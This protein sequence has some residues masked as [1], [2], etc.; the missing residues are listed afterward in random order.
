L[1]LST[2]GKT[3]IGKFSVWGRF[4]YHR[5]MED[6]TRLRH[7]TRINADAPVYF[8]SLKNNYYERD[9]YTL[10]TALQ[11]GF[12][13]Q[14]L[15]LTLGLDYRVGNHF[16]NNDPRGRISDFQ[17]DASAAL[18]RRFESGDMHLEVVYGYGRERV[19]VGYKNDQ[20]ANNTADPRYINYF[21]NGFGRAQEQVRDIRYNNDFDR[22]GANVLLSKQINNGNILFVKAGW[23]HEQQ[24]FKFYDSS[25]LMYNPLNKYNKN[26]YSFD[27]LWKQ[28]NLSNTPRV[29][30]LQGALVDGRDY[31]YA[32]EQNNYVFRRNFVQLEVSDR[33]RNT[34]VKGGLLFVSSDMEDGFAGIELAYQ[35]LSPSIKLNQYIPLL[36]QSALVPTV[37]VGY[38]K[39]LHHNFVLP[40]SFVSTFTQTIMQ[41]NYLYYTTSS[42][43]LGV[44][45]D[46]ELTRN[47]NSSFVLGIQSD[48]FRHS[49]MEET[50]SFIAS[51]GKDRLQT[52]VRLTAF[53]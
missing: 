41:H 31:N 43:Q 50:S 5:S 46:Y 9:V 19:G 23:L 18:G 38:N 1:D 33:Y 12:A 10:Q 34:A 8:G 4:G 49:D 47:A 45:V 37:S 11:Y 6:S 28:G 14:R 15:P 16:S 39:V 29:Y 3:A 17:L 27:I 35:T 40:T 7:Q 52:N 32:I 21:M 2:E 44:G 20:Y 24:F 26:S 42:Y 36:K 48:Y 51:P 53:F 22:Y 13:Q 30:R 25:P